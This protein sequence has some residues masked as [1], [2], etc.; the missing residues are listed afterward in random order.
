MGGRP[1]PQAAEMRPSSITPIAKTTP[2]AAVGVVRR[3]RLFAALDRRGGAAVVWVTGPPG[4]GKTTLVASYLEARGAH[5]GWYQIDAGDADPGTFFHFIAIAAAARLRRR[6]ALHLER[7][8]A[9]YRDDVAGFARRYFQQLYGALPRPFMLVLDNYQALPAAARVHEAVLA[10]AEELPAEGCLVVLSRE[11]PPPALVRLRANRALEMIGWPRLRLTRAESDAIVALA[12]VELE[13]YALELLHRRADGWAA[14]LILLLEQALA[15]GHVSSPPA[16]SPKLVFD[17]LA[18][19]LFEGFDEEARRLLLRTAFL[20]EVSAS[21]AA[22]LGAGER[23]EAL[24]ER[25]HRRLHLV[26]IRAGEHGPSYCYHPLLRDFLQ[27]RAALDLD[28]RTVRA[29]RRDSAR[30]LEEAGRIEEAA[31]LLEEAGDW[32]GLARLITARAPELLH[33]GRI[34]TLERW[35]EALPAKVRGARPWLLYWQAQCRFLSSAPREARLLYERAYRRFRGEGPG[36]REGLLLTCAGAMEAVIHELD[37][38]ALLDPWIEV[39]AEATSVDDPTLPAEV[40]ARV[41]ASM[42]MALVFRQPHHPE[43]GRWAESALREADQIPEA[44]ARLSVQLLVAINLIYTGQFARVRELIAAMRR[45]CRRPQV[46]ALALTVLKDVESMHGMLT[47]DYQGCLKAV[48]DGLAVAERY[49]VR[50]WIGHLIS[51]GVAGALG[52]G[53]LETAAELLARMDERREVAGRLDRCNF[54]YYSA[55]LAMLR[56]DHLLAHQHQRTALHLA[57]ECGCPFYE[58][59]CRMALALVL[60]AAGEARRAAGE[61]RAVHA[62]ARPINNRLLEF[63][64]LLVYAHVALGNGR[65]RSGLN[66]LRYALALGREH[67]FSHSLWWLPEVMSGL[68]ARALAAGFEVDYVRGLVRARGLV[69]A[70]AGAEVVDWPWRFRARCLGPFTIERDGEPLG[71]IAPLRRRPLELLRCLIALGA[72]DVPEALVAEGLWPRIDADYAHRSLTTTLH[73]LRKLLGEDR[74]LLLRHGRLSLNPRYWWL[75]VRAF[76]IAVAEIDG[77][78]APGAPRPAVARLAAHAERLL[79]LYRGAFLAGEPERGYLAAARERHRSRFLRCLGDLARLLEKAGEREAAIGYYRR[80]LEADP[81]AEGFYRRLMLCYRAGGRHAEAVEVYDTC[82]RTFRAALEV[83]P[84]PETTA[85]Y[86]S[87]LAEL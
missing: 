48:Y 68:C 77:E 38:F 59:L 82:R 63:M 40:R 29:L 43:I 58:A 28:R 49:G 66:A 64:A 23:A 1:R 21:M 72:E 60:E 37:D 3:E 47:A 15:D 4:S 74:A 80:A 2:P 78:L 81:L 53:D 44:N 24:L 57:V 33:Q 71:R 84:S 34:D 39:V 20:P 25:I 13:D 46:S 54:H 19:E 61:L 11:P 8:A 62:I 79:G 87:L 42:F 55:W 56:G 26:A 10:A 22:A 70:A 17:Y 9:E 35:L 73:R 16:L 69:P 83:E 41:T 32:R 86:R 45:A 27:A 85:I 7:F 51:N 52:A 12:G 36:A 75:D 67:G 31:A 30:L 65:E 76:E 50:T 14:G 18:G 5:A 6:R